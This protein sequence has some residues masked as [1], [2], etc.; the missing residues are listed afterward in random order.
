MIPGAP[1]GLVRE[2]PACCRAEAGLLVLGGTVP[3]P[4]VVGAIGRGDMDG[5][6]RYRDDLRRIKGRAQT[7]VDGF[8]K[9]LTGTGKDRLLGVTIVGQVAR[10]WKRAHAPRRLLAWADRWLR[11]NRG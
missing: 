2:H 10:V 4:G 11:Q 6:C 1:G 7:E 9:V 3:G 5:A 8:I